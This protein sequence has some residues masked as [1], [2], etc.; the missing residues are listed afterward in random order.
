[1]IMGRARFLCITELLI[2]HNHSL[3]ISNQRT[4]DRSQFLHPSPQ[5]SLQ[6][7]LGN[8]EIIIQYVNI[9]MINKWKTN[10][11]H[12]IILILLGTTCR[13]S[14]IHRHT[15]THIIH[16]YSIHVYVRRH[17]HICTW[18]IFLLRLCL[19][20]SVH[21]LSI[22]YGISMCYRSMLGHDDV[23]KWNH[24][25]RY[26]PYV[27]G[28]HRW[29]VISPHKGSNAELW[30]ILWSAP[31]DIW[32]TWDW[33][34]IWGPCRPKQVSKARKAI[35]FRSIPSPVDIGIGATSS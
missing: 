11:W 24:F 28:I 33:W 15:R 2:R 7:S 13:R 10:K 6:I 18:Y 34:H 27:R 35:T 21:L 9:W 1:M 31:E 3:L 26:W 29:P 30:Y 22:W 19:E 12:D 20:Q 25:T 23:I 8:S 16:E 17:A 14:C 32:R 5:N 4:V